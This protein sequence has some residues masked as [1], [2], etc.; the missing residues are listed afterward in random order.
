[1]RAP[2][3]AV[4][5]RETVPF[6]YSFQR[7]QGVGP[8][9]PAL[10]SDPNPSTL[11]GSAAAAYATRDNAFTFQLT[12]AGPQPVGLAV[13]VAFAGTGTPGE[14]TVVL[15]LYDAQ[16]TGTWF[17]LVPSTAIPIGQV[18]EIEVPVVMSALSQSWTLAVVLSVA[19]PT[20]GVYSCVAGL[21]ESALTQ[22]SGSP[23]GSATAANQLLQLAQETATAVAAAALA[24]TVEPAGTSASTAQAIQ[25]EAGGV[26]VATSAALAAAL[27]ASVDVI[28]T[29]APTAFASLAAGPNGIRV[30]SHPLN[31]PFAV[32]R[33]ATNASTTTGTPL[34]TGE[35]DTFAVQN[36]D[37]LLV[38]LESAVSGAT[39]ISARQA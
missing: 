6:D 31:D 22:A 32:I 15:Y 29:T 17:V 19:A 2:G 33:V 1:L 23:A 16:E 12:Q 39:A 38:C 36:A 3:R 21:S 9:P 34:A 26:P 13:A 30:S 4:Q 5:P 8:P 20:T 24:A 37:E 18:T 27:N 10:G 28:A 7:G 35:K 25:G 11:T 14:A